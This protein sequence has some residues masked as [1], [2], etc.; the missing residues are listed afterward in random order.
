MLLDSKSL[1]NIVQT[2]MGPEEKI[3]FDEIFQK[4][5]LESP[6]KA[7]LPNVLQFIEEFDKQAKH[8]YYRWTVLG[9]GDDE[10]NDFWIEMD[11]INNIRKPAYK[12]AAA[13]DHS[14][15]NDYNQVLL[16]LS[17]DEKVGYWFKN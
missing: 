12:L 9:C 7:N 14:K 2:I 10:G 1:K 8:E 17:T 15:F 5:Y 13:L 4:H 11:A 16:S 6:N 3:H